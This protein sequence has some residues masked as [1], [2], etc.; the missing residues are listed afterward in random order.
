MLH[1]NQINAF[2]IALTTQEFRSALT[3]VDFYIQLPPKLNSLISTIS[4]LTDI[5]QLLKAR[6]TLEPG[7]LPKRSEVSETQSVP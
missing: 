6:L 1:F 4:V 7:I 2:F 5:F 3:N